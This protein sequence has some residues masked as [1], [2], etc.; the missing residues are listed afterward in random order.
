MIYKQ[1]S[2]TAYTRNTQLSTHL[3]SVRETD[4][5]VFNTRVLFVDF[6]DQTIATFG[7]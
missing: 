3:Q 1:N 4:P 7:L 5:V 2:V 6:L